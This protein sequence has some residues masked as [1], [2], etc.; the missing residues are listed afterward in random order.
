MTSQ[1]E[2]CQYLVDIGNTL[3][4]PNSVKEL[5]G[6]PVDGKK[7]RA[8]RKS[9]F[10]V[11]EEL[12]PKIEMSKN[13]LSKLERKGG[14]MNPKSFR[15]LAGVIKKTP[16]ELLGI[17]GADPLHPPADSHMRNVGPV[18]SRSYAI[19]TYLLAPSATHWS[20]LAS[21]ED[22]SR[23]FDPRVIDQGLFR[24][25][26]SGD[27]MEPK[28]RDGS[29][30]EFKIWREGKEPL[31]LGRNVVVTNSDGLSTFK[32]LESYDPERE[33][34]V[35]RALNKKYPEPIRIPRQMLA[36]LAVAMGTFTPE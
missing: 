14:G 3:P 19:P 17:I 29:L 16:D 11:Q 23:E 9:L 6:I 5:R 21:A 8:L 35:L 33:E 26:I 36:R 13:N 15:L 12:A 18:E 20:E 7:L 32:H 22:D 27:C 4:L 28:Y 25:R 1:E 2:N 34:W 10:V 30:V 31:P 24:I